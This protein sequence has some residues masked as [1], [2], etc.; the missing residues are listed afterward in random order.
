MLVIRRRLDMLDPLSP[1][2]RQR[3]EAFDLRGLVDEI[4]AS[5]AEQFRR[6]KIKAVVRLASGKERPVPVK[7]VKGMIVQVLENLIDNSI[8]WLKQSMRVDPGFSPSLT[9]DLD[10]GGHELRFADNGPGIPR[11]R[12]E[13]VFK[14]FVSFKPPG[15]GKGLGLYISK[16]I[17]RY[18]NSDLSLLDDADKRGRLHTFVLDIDGLQA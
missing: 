1:S 8:F 11:M 4:L 6:H 9:I 13:E 17:A 15:L 16:E 10:P 3:K 7:A 12:A 18:H 2:G 14:P 5:H